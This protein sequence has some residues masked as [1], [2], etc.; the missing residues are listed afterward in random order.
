MLCFVV[1][2]LDYYN[3][4]T[5]EQSQLSQPTQCYFITVMMLQVSAMNVIQQDWFKVA[6]G[7]KANVT[8]VDGYMACFEDFSTELLEHIVNMTDGNVRVRLCTFYN[9]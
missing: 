2:F 7:P 3:I 5:S 6:S 1:M 4:H 8:E 9:N